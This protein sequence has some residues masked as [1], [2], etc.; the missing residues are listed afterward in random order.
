MLEKINLKNGWKR[1]FLTSFIFLMALSSLFAFQDITITDEVKENIK[2]RIKNGESV[3]IV[4]GVVNA[5]GGREYFSYGKTRMKG[6]KAVDEYSIYE[7]GS[8][9]KVFTG[10]VF[11][12]M[13]VHRELRLEDTVQKYLPSGVKIPTRN[14]DSITLE[15]L[16]THTSALPRMPANFRPTDFGN[17]YADF[18]VKEMYDFLSACTLARNIGEKYEYSNLATGLLGHILS[19]KAGMSYEQLIIER[20]CLVLGMNSTVITLTPQL[21]KRLAKGHNAREEVP[22]WDIPT[23][24]GAGALRSSA[25]DMITFMAANMGV[26]RSKLSEAMDLSHEKRIDASETMKVGINWHIRDNGTTKII[27][28]NGGTG[29]Y[30]TFCGFIKDKKIGV[31]VLSNMNIGADDIGF[32]LLDSSSKLKKSRKP[33]VLKSE[34]LEK[35]SGEYQLTK[36]KTKVI[37]SRDGNKLLMK[38]QGQPEILIFPESETKFFMKEAPIQV[39]FKMNASGKVSGLIIHQGGT[40]TEA[41]KIK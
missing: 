5:R 22:N 18:T 21:K 20:I 11:A 31:V 3:G 17:P 2:E 35:Y 37:I 36:N 9:S 16:A 4:V 8:I 24:A 14:G 12:D 10:I 33:L 13:V 34:I 15:H 30:R 26:R 25:D 39:T 6:G 40:D 32:H 1:L 27:W 23:L 29:G 7:I 28:H 38:V 19:L 41:K